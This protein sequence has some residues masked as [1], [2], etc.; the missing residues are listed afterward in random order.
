METWSCEDNT[1]WPVNTDAE[2]YRESFEAAQKE[3]ALLKRKVEILTQQL[4]E[5]RKMYDLDY[6]LFLL[7]ENKVQEEFRKT[8]CGSGRTGV[9]FQAIFEKVTS[10]YERQRKWCQTPGFTGSPVAAA[11]SGKVMVGGSDEEDDPEME[12]HLMRLLEEGR[13]Q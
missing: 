4:M 13:K 12:A 8:P 2:I 5:A 10:T 7:R 11:D 6:Q 9:G 3:I 1:L